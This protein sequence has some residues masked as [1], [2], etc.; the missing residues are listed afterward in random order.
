VTYGLYPSD[1]VNQAHLELIPAMELKTHIIYV[2]EV[3]AGTSIG[4]GGTFVT[5]RKSRIATI[6]VGYGDGYPRSL[7]N[8]GSVL[9]RGHKVPIVGRIC[10]DQFMVDVTDY[11]DIL[12]HDEVTLVGRDGDRVLR[13]EEVS[14]L[15]GS[16]NYEFCCDVGRRIPRVYYKNGVYDKTVDYFSD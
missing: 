10:M 12:E 1:E 2:K 6:P 15:A 14:E 16:F 13:V 4:Y 7:S 11:P 9:V 5:E 8:R 3:P